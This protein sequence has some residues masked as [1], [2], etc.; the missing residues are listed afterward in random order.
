MGESDTIV[1]I[2]PI[3]AGKSTVSRLL[4][5][6]TG[7]RRCALD[8]V[9]WAYYAERGYD[10]SYA[11]QMA[12]SDAGVLGEIRYTRP[13]EVHAIERVLA[14]HTPGILDFGASNSVFDEEPLLVRVERALAPFPH[15][16]LLMPSADPDESIAILRERLTAMIRAGGEEPGDELWRVNEYFVRH[17]SNYR[18]ATHVVYT[19][20]S[21][22]DVVC[23]DVLAACGLAPRLAKEGHQ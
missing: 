3:G 4:A 5:E 18:L 22:P 16:V 14:A 20:H 21:T 15:V 23:A 19:G 8:D 2:G 17:P 1:L 6:P 13:Y 10:R 9:R 7:W 11:Q 12:V